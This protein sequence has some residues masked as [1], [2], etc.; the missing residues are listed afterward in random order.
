MANENIWS[1]GGE[2]FIPCQRDLAGQC[3]SLLTKQKVVKTK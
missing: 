1:D 3:F 2:I